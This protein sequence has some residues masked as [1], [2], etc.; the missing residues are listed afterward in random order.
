MDNNVGRLLHLSALNR[1]Y[2]LIKN[3]IIENPP[4]QFKENVEIGNFKY[5]IYG[6]D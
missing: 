2:K 4:G 5:S 3:K 1:N 6:L